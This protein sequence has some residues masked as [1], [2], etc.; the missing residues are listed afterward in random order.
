MHP[1]QAPLTE[2]LSLLTILGHGLIIMTAVLL[3]LLRGQTWPNWLVKIGQNGLWFAWGIALI[4]MGGS[5]LYS[6]VIGLEP[7][8]MCWF[9]RICMYPQVVLL[10]LAAYWKDSR[11]VRY[12]LPLTAIGAALSTYHYSLQLGVNPYAPCSAVGY[13]VS[14]SD[15]FILNYGY[16]TIPMMALTAFLLISLLLYLNYRVSQAT[17]AKKSVR[18]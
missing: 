13:S 4:A 2:V 3:V 11:I 18:K 9:Q 16:I 10:G 7:C 17:S 12:A 14:C 5:L 6:D 1:L 8:L 15:R